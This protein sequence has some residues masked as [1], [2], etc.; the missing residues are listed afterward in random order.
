DSDSDSDSSDS[1][2]DNNTEP[3]TRNVTVRK[4]R[5]NTVDYLNKLSLKRLPVVTDDNL[6]W[7]V[8][9]EAFKETKNLY[10][11]NENVTRLQDAIK[12]ERV[13]RIGGKTLFNPKTYEE[14]LKNI[15]KRLKHN[16]KPL[17]KEASELENHISI[18]SHQK[19]KIIEYIDKLR[20]FDSLSKAYNEKSY[21]NNQKFIANVVNVLPTFLKT[22]WEKKQ[23][24]LESKHKS[25]SLSNLIETLTKFIPTLELSIRNESFLNSNNRKDKEEKERRRFEKPRLYHFEDKSKIDNIKV[26]CW[27][28]KSDSHTFNKC[29][30]LW[31][32]NGKDVTAIAKKNGICT[33]CGNEWSS[34]KNCPNDKL[35]CR[36]EGCSLPH[37][38]IF[39]YKR[40]PDRE[41][42]K[43]EHHSNN[44][45]FTNINS[46]RNNNNSDNPLPEPG[47]SRDRKDDEM[48]TLIQE[49]SNSH[50]YTNNFTRNNMLFVD[51]SKLI[52]SCH[53]NSTTCNNILSVIV[54]KLN[55][56]KEVALLIDSGSTVSLIEESVANELQIRGPWL[57]LELRWSGDQKRYDDYSR[58]VKTEACGLSSS[59]SYKLYF[60]TVRKL[61]IASQKFIASEFYD[62]Y[63][64]LLPLNLHDYHEI[65]GVI[66]IDNIFV[67]EQIK[68]VKPKTKDLSAPFGVRCLLGD[69]IFGS[70]YSLAK[71]YDQLIID[72]KFVKNDNRYM[73]HQHELMESEIKELNEM[74]K[75]VMGLDYN[76]P[77]EPNDKKIAEEVYAL[78]VLNN[79]IIQKPNSSHYVAPLLW[80]NQPFS[81][82]YINSF[83][84][85]LRR[86]LIVEK[87][88]YKLNKFQECVSQIQNLLTKGYAKELTELEVKTIG[89]KTYYNPIFFIHPPNKRVRMIWDLA[90][91]VNG[92]SLNDFLLSGPNMYNS[93]LEIIF[94]MRER[95]YFIK[96]DLNEM[97][98]QIFVTDEDTDSLRF[99]FRIN[100]E[101]KI[102][103]FKMLVLPFGAKCS[104][105]ISQHV[106]NTI[107]LKFKNDLPEASETIL[108]SSYVDDIVRSVDTVKQ[109]VDITIHVKRILRTG[110][111][112]LLKINSNVQEVINEIRGKLTSIEKSHEKVFSNETREKLL[113]YDIDF[114]NDT[115]ALSLNLDKFP[116]SIIHGTER[117]NKREVLQVLMTL[118]DPIGLFQFATSKMK[119]LYH[120]LCQ[121]NYTWDQILN[122]DHFTLWKNCIN[123]FKDI[124]KINVPRIYCSQYKNSSQIQLWA[125]GDAGKDIAC[126]AIY[127]RFLNDKNQQLGKNSAK[128]QAPLMGDLPSV[129]LAHH[130][131]AFTNAMVDLAGPLTVNIYRNIIAKRYIFVYS[132]LTTRAIHLELIERMDSESTLIALTNTINLRGAPKIIISDNGLN[133]KGASNIL[134]S[135]VNKWNVTLLKKGIITSPI[136]WKFG[137]PRSPHFQGA[138]ERMVGLTKIILKKIIDMTTLNRKL[139]NDF[140]LKAILNEVI[141]ILNNRPLVLIPIKGTNTEI[142][143]P[144]YFLIGRQSIQTL[145]CSV[146]LKRTFNES[147]EDLKVITNILWGHWIKYYLP[148]ILLR[149]KWIDTKEPLKVGDIVITVDTIV[150]NSWRI[151]KIVDIIIGSKNQVREYRV[152]L[153]KNNSIPELKSL[154]L[155][156]LMKLYK[157]EKYS[158]VNRGALYVAKLNLDA[159]KM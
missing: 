151:G 139:F 87:Q 101:D 24:K 57:P 153:G 46:N 73:N 132:C 68:L 35:K 64:Y 157:D 88:A 96:G 3:D 36:V 40:K 2:T 138:V 145:P 84:V 42:N 80:V 116:S 56:K 90:A 75:E 66:G 49:L 58:I 152:L 123:W 10:S 94:K 113:G 118:F 53:N 120:K 89:K 108:K 111:F 147:Y 81:L 99:L 76:L 109:A 22:A 30:D 149:E 9:Y 71:I 95:T 41:L 70:F 28:H 60:R 17:Y 122:E 74:E 44:K 62:K 104:P 133:F 143:T 148:T 86:F 59:K 146:N 50:L 69:Y 100:P 102:R 128:P 136:E 6:S 26:K 39:C 4:V 129:R 140:M 117:P 65:S 38:S 31:R 45:K 37:H 110:G 19:A 43:R 156:Q 48:E 97:F 20:N 16:L 5:E 115:L 55:Q 52:N 61:N 83:K 119:I 103:V 106:K 12:D 1:D 11:N 23:A 134:E 85:A 144:N 137:P 7:C 21:S 79:K 158:V 15:N 121:E 125:F 124:T 72:N 34:H 105:V 154:S 25:V 159:I 93:L 18:K 98:H 8:F 13:I 82:D 135:D 78:E 142:L 63:P 150:A 91:K 67:F 155:K 51:N 130:N 114:K 141:G 33:Y 112:N 32:M 131:P 27:Y 126:G 47:C 77:V 127:L 29:K 107:A 54:L 92:K 14:C